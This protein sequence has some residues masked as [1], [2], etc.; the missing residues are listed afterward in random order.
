MGPDR[1][2]S[3]EHVRDVI[4]R[5]LPPR[6]GRDWDWNVSFVATAR[7]SWLFKAASPQA[8]WPLAVKVYCTAVP[9][10]LPARQLQVLRQ[11]HDSMA[12]RAD[13]TVPAPWA[14]LPKHRALMMEWIDAPRVD[15]LLNRA[16]GR[17]D[18]S[19]IMAA[20]G[21]W[22]R[23]FH[24]QGEQDVRPLGDL[25]LLR[26]LNTIMGSAELAAAPDPA[27]R[28]AYAA[29]QD[30]VRDLGD[31]PVALV[32]AHGDFSPP[33]LFL[34][35]D[36]AVGFD[37]KAIKARPAAHDI[38]HF[39]VFAKAFNTPTWRQLTSNVDRHDFEAFLGGYGALDDAMD[40]RL[41]MVFRLAEALR[42]WAHLLVRARREGG[43]LRR[44]TRIRRLRNMATHA[45]RILRR[46]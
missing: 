33:N 19:R 4:L 31:V 27:F 8:P 17:T 43:T 21:R 38:M 5:D 40:A 6:A 25:D 24:D 29:L 34:G 9:D 44:M 26:P 11:Y 36:R 16:F 39:L 18:R 12:G 42:S 23:H 32:T 37:F 41:L 3:A 46:G 30:C 13:L 22:L 28:T 35:D 20:A 1:A 45:A 14:A 7:E 2:V 10:A 15:K